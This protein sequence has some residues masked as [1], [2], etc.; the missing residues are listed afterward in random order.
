M[1]GRGASARV[2]SLW[3]AIEARH[4]ALPLGLSLGDEGLQLGV[5][6]PQRDGLLLVHFKLGEA[7]LQL[8]FV[9]PSQ[10]QLGLELGVRVRVLLTFVS[11]C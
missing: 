11:P 2:Q 4:L 6:R 7:L 10:G 1:A 8:T 3:V 5:V 9:S